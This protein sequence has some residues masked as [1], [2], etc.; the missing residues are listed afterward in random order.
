MYVLYIYYIYTVYTIYI[1]VYIYICMYIQTSQIYRT[2]TMHFRS[3]RRNPF[4]TVCCYLENFA[5]DKVINFDHS[6]P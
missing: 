1:Y 6:I 4:S 3:I 2:I 5:F